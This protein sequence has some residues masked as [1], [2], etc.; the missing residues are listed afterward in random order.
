MTPMPIKQVNPPPPSPRLSS[1]I[2]SINRPRSYCKCLWTTRIELVQSWECQG[3]T[4]S[5]HPP[6]RPRRRA[7]VIS[8]AA[9]FYVDTF[10]SFG[11]ISERIIAMHAIKLQLRR[12]CALL[13]RATQSSFMCSYSSNPPRQGFPP[14]PSAVSSTL[15]ALP[16][17]VIPRISCLVS[18][19]FHSSCRPQLAS[20]SLPP[21][22]LLLVIVL[23]LSLQPQVLFEKEPTRA[24]SERI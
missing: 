22:L 15:P 16:S 10:V 8:L 14:H 20:S 24:Q 21:L 3:S 23:Q 6:P 9:Q 17:D 7:S 12:Y 18:E 13:L 11:N 5:C 2:T 4:S 19:T 1:N